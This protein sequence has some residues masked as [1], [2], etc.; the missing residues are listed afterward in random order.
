MLY[1]KRLLASS[2]TVFTLDDLKKIWQIKNSSYLR[3]LVNRLNKRGEIE[4]L[5]R[6]IYAIDENFNELELANRLKAPSYVSLETV[7]QKE[8]IVFQNYGQ[9]IFS[10]SNNTVS[11]NVAG[12]EFKYFKIADEILSNPLGIEIKDGAYIA[13]AERAVCDRAYLTP[14]YYF[15]NLRP[16][17]LAALKQISKIYNK[18]AQKEIK[19]LIGKTCV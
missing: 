16:L 18:R 15:D 17:N 6:G 7:L 13:S 19:Q 12:R 5:Q 2:Q 4:R 11:K 10:I 8:N 3:V 1:L 9:A 14:N